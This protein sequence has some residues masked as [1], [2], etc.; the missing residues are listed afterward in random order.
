MH[1]LYF[2]GMNFTCKYYSIYE[3]WTLIRYLALEFD[4][5][6]RRR[7]RDVSIRDA[8]KLVLSTKCNNFKLHVPYVVAI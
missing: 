2:N 7:Q 4:K 5:L 8:Y 1:C 6:R 3:V